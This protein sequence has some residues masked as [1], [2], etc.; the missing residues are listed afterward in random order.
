MFPGLC[1]RI[2]GEGKGSRPRM[3]DEPRSPARHK[4]EHVVPTVIHDPEEKMPVLAR[5]LRHAMENQTRFWSL[6]ALLAVVITGLAIV[7][8]GLSLGGS[9][10]DAA[11]LKI[12]KAKTPSE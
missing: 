8:K 4:L 9:S 11:W 3:R 10:S 1:F 5:W 2:N 6:I 7:S 12:E